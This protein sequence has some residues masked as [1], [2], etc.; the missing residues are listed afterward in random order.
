MNGCPAPES[1]SAFP[2]NRRPVR[3]IYVVY[4]ERGAGVEPALKPCSA[5]YV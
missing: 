2:L 5:A 1:T 4:L 3:N